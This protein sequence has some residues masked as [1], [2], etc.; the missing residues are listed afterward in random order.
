MNMKNQQK[1][2]ILHGKLQNV[3]WKLSLPAIA[4][5]VLFGLNAFL[6]TVFVGQLINETALAG[7]ALAYPL[8]SIMWG[9]G[10][11]AGTGAASALSIALGANDIT[12]QKKLLGNATLMMGVTTAVFA[13]PAYIFAEPLI[14][15]MGG[16]GAI[17]QEGVRYFKA[18]LIGSFFWVYGLGL[19][20][21]IRGE[22]KMK[23]A[24]IMMTY[25][26]ALN[27]VLNPIFIKVLGWGVEGAAWATNIGMALYCV[28]EYLYFTRGKASFEA[29]IFSINYDR[30]VFRS[31]VSMGM[32]GFIMSLMGLVQAIVVFNALS[33]YGT[34][35]DLAFFAAANRLMLFL[36]TPL[37][38]LMRAMQP[39]TGISFGAGDYDRV[40]RSFIIFTKAGF[41]I[42]TPFWLF[43]TLFPSGALHLV[44]PDMVFTAAELFNFRMYMAV[45]PALPIVFM[46]LTFFPSINE[47]KY[48]SIVGLAR[49]LVFYV[50]VMLLLPRLLGIQWIYLGSTLID[51]LLT[52]WIAITMRRLFIKLSQKQ[53]AESVVF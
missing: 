15:M 1:E 43:L 27:I 4:A 34:E 47:G 5:M 37:F 17:L 39:V 16:K 51:I 9:L 36:M 8:T 32:P 10:S 46:A 40:K 31:I 50:P 3:M 42:I 44:L 38:G 11:L 35:R 52:A 48:G 18:T 12:T 49:Q 21:I 25:G 24:A 19:N 33:N 26:L 13:I 6:D 2:L 28:V 22:G 14:Q 41:Y 20:F 7:V 45:L 29:Q 53:E 23:Q 30:S